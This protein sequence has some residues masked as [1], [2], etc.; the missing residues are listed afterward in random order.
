M[1]LFG[2]LSKGGV[3]R[4]GE[5]NGGGFGASQRMGKV[6]VQGMHSATPNTLNIYKAM[7]LLMH[8][9]SPSFFPVSSPCEQT[10]SSAVPADTKYSTHKLVTCCMTPGDYE[11]CNSSHQ[12]LFSH[13]RTPHLHSSISLYRYGW[14]IYTSLHTMNTMKCTCTIPYNHHMRSQH[15]HLSRLYVYVWGSHQVRSGRHGG[16]GAGPRALPGLLLGLL[17]FGLRREGV[18]RTSDNSLDLG[19]QGGSAE[20]STHH[21][22]KPCIP[23]AFK[24]L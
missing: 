10:A 12:K 22:A 21:Q 3:G 18:S 2:Y 1:V 20:R 24:Q 9:P 5:K 15:M 17:G 16:R 14:T 4:E 11:P 8:T 6:Q 7:A 13:Q 19:S 23:S